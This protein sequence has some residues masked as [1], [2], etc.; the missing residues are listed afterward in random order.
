VESDDH[1]EM[2]KRDFLCS[3]KIIA[4]SSHWDD[5]MVACLVAIVVS[6]WIYLIYWNFVLI[7]LSEL[8]WQVVY[9]LEEKWG[10]FNCLAFTL[11]RVCVA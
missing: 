9:N 5:N 3:H 11:V 8:V 7:K 1:I 6:N 2:I 10:E 4:I